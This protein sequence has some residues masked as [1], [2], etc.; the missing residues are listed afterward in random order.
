[1]IRAVLF[2]FDGVVAKTL[3]SHAR[4]WQHVLSPLGIQVDPR[5]IALNE[6]QPAIEI[7]RAILAKNGLQLPEERLRELVRAKREHYQ[8]TTRAKAYEGVQE[9]LERLKER[10]YKTALVTGSIRSNMEAAVG[11]ELLDRFDVVLT[12]EDIP[13]GK[14]HPDPFLEAAKRLGVRPEECLVIENAP[15]GI[16]AAK[17][18]GMRCLVVLSTLPLPDLAGADY[19]VGRISEIDLDGP[20][21]H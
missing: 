17:A 18:A 9:L 16:R 4:S 12:S 6:G 15:M 10:D 20:Y 3:D 21:F 8:K 19:Y 11:R 7:L 1:M 5:D 13:R 2:D 14:P